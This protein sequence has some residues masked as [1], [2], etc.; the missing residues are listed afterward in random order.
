MRLFEDPVARIGDPF[1]R[2]AAELAEL[3][4]GLTAPNPWV[5]CVLVSPDGRIVG[6]GFHERA[7]GPHAEVRAI[8][9]AGEAASGSTAYVTLEPCAHH[10]KTPPCVDALATAGVASVV[11]GVIDPD[12]RARDG[13]LRLQEL[14][15][16][17][18]YV[19]AADAAALGDQLEEWL[20]CNTAGRP[21]LTVKV[22]LSID[23]KPSTLPGARTE[24]TGPDGRVISMRLRRAA[25]TVLVG[26][27]TLAGDDPALTRRA[28][29]GTPD[30]RQP[31]RAVLCG[32]TLPPSTAQIFTDGLGPAALLVPHDTSGAQLAPFVDSGVEVALY[33]AE[34][35]VASAADALAGLGAVHVLAETGPRTFTSIWDSGLLDA[36][37][38]VTAGG[39]AGV[40]APGIYRGEDEFPTT[41]LERRVYA[42]EAGVTGEVATVQWRRKI[43]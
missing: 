18:R 20:L 25:D 27:T 34:R 7:G 9:D 14:G 21:W 31:L 1:M 2:R 32:E 43:S 26:A 42:L 6:E 30:V 5:G 19:S 35:G 3:G 13:A 12:P 17:V 37:V 40:Q 39:I 15:I 36:L 11:V 23:A 33:A 8:A 22:G 24:I 38:I 28:E 10:G 29:D 4:R 41:E 16:D